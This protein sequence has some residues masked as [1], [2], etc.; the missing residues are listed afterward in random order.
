MALCATKVT[1]PDV[2]TAGDDEQDAIQ[3]IERV[4]SPHFDTWIA[5]G[6]GPTKA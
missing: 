1:G 2:E 5:Q 3:V 6:T 4:F